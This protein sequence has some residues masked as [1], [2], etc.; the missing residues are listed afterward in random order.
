MKIIKIFSN[1]G[2]SEGA[3]KTY[4]DL[5]ELKNDKEYNVNYKFTSKD[6]YTHVIILNTSM[7]VLNIDKNNVI[8]LAF[9]PP[10]FLNLTKEFYEYAQKNIGSYYIGNTNNLS[11]PFISHFSYMWHT[12]FISVVP[13]KT[14]LIS[15]MVSDKNRAPGHRYRHILV[16]NILK[17]NLSIDIY[18][19]GC[20]FYS[21]LKD[22]RVKGEFKGKEP[23]LNYKFHIAIENFQ[24]KDY[25]SEKIM[26]PIICSCTPIYLGAKNIDNYFNNI[27]QLSGN[28]KNDLFLLNNI[29]NNPNSFYK[30]N[31]ID[32]VKKTINIKNIINKFN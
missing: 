13:N 3:I 19:R 6:D 8:G 27:I 16:Q 21:N 32:D 18:G 10:E 31:Q 26:D 9:E 17:L 29:I 22:N 28:I 1:F 5:C 2:T 15:I 14:K 24:T 12:P 30:P 23:Y 25:F 20:K 7:P 11:T 4:I